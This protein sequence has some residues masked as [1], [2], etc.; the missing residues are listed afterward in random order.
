MTYPAVISVITFVAFFL[1]TTIVPKIGDIITSL[2][3]ADAKL[4]VYTIALLAISKV[5]NNLKF[6]VSFL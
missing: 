2:G 6:I 5:L 4:P 3:G 1:M